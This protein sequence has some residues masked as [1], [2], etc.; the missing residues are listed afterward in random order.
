[1]NNNERAGRSVESYK[2]LPLI[3]MTS[4]RAQ[5]C[6]HSVSL[7]DALMHSESSLD[8]S[9]I[10]RMQPIHAFFVFMVING[11]NIIFKRW[12]PLGV[13]LVTFKWMIIITKLFSFIFI[14]HADYH[15]I[16]ICILTT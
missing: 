4:V 12:E 8:G 15:L 2:T 14:S 10:S 5:T 13:K 1:M 11:A 7:S 9:G 3:D 16:D 6:S